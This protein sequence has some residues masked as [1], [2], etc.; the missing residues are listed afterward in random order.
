MKAAR[1]ERQAGKTGGLIFA[2]LFQGLVSSYVTGGSSS[3]SESVESHANT[4]GQ[5]QLHIP[6]QVLVPLSMKSPSSSSVSI[7][8]GGGG[9]DSQEKKSFGFVVP[10][11]RVHGGSLLSRLGGSFKNALDAGL[12]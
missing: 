8:F 10:E 2:G 9:G 7:G 5:Q 4:G 1:Q 3:V 12:V 11:G 6:P